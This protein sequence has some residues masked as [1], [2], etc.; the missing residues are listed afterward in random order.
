[1]SNNTKHTPGPWIVGPMSDY[2]AAKDGSLIAEI[3]TDYSPI[4]GEHTGAMVANARLIAAAPELLSACR[5]ALR[6]LDALS[7][8]AT[9]GFPK[10]NRAANMLRAAIAKAEGTK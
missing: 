5:E 3:P 2:I 6:S 9:D 8:S 10:D 7:E 1:M 4:T